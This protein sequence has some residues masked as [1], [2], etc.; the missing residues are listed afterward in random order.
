[1]ATVL[2][3]ADIMSSPTAAC[4]LGSEHGEP[5]VSFFV[6]DTPPGRGPSLHTHPYA[7]VFIVLEGRSTF[8]VGD[9]ELLV[10]AGHVVVVPPETPHGFT[11]G[12]QD[13]LRQVNIHPRDR[14]ETTWL[15]EG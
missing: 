11:N 1:M 4:F 13:P 2:P 10:D 6:T 15:E 3:F 14:M 12:T 5:G 7:E 8:R 9:E